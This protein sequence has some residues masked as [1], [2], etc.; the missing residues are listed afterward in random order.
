MNQW[1]K[2]RVKR[3]VKRRGALSDVAGRHDMIAAREAA[4]P[5]STRGDTTLV[6]PEGIPYG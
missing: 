4:H 2:R 3:R 5:S 1:M 6:R